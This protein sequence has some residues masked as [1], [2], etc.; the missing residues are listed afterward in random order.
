ME[1][2]NCKYCK[3]EKEQ[4]GKKVGVMIVKNYDKKEAKLYAEHLRH[5][6]NN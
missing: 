1:K 6:H 4:E 5:K 3:S 2:E